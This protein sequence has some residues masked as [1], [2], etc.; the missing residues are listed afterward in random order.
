MPDN[1]THKAKECEFKL[2]E[3]IDL[4]NKRHLGTCICGA[5][6]TV[7][8]DSLKKGTFC[9]N[10]ECKY[11]Q[12]ARRFDLTDMK[13]II[14][15]KKCIYVNHFGSGN[16]KGVEIICECKFEQDLL[17]SHFNTEK[18]CKNFKCKHYRD[19]Q[20][21][22]TEAIKDLIES[23]G[24][25]VPEN[26]EYKTNQQYVLKCPNNHDFK[27]TIDNWKRYPNSRCITCNGNGRSLSLQELREF[28]S[29]YDC[30]IK[31]G[32]TEYKGNVTDYVV[33]YICPNGHY[34]N[35]LTKNNFNG[36]INQNLGPCETCNEEKRKNDRFDEISNQLNTRDCK[37]I[38]L[39]ER[40]V[41][42]ICKCG[43][44]CSSYDNNILKDN[45]IGCA[46][47]GNPF[48][49][50]EIQ[51]QI[52]ETNKVKYGCENVFQS[53]LIKEKIKETNKER[54]GCE[55]VMQNKEIFN[56]NMDSSKKYKNY[57]FPSGRIDEIQ[58]FENITLDY[59]LKTYSENDIFTEKN[60][61]IK[62]KYK[63]PLTNNTSAY[64]PD[65]YVKS[66]NMIVETKSTYTFEKNIEKNEAKFKKVVELGHKM[67]VFI[68]SK[69]KVLYKRI[70][71][72]DG[73]IV[74]EPSNPATLIFED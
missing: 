21:L 39:N 25:K 10:K 37:I 57:R 52:K 29:K 51:E 63:N 59:L 60:I 55:N 71:N 56:R 7:S 9:R 48:N 23:E 70:Y 43:N 73:S 11:Y 8:Y 20:Q 2:Q 40:K 22:S 68:C 61:N 35:N 69:E 45:F 62:I 33:P 74:I 66:E 6:Q 38:S 26:F 72:S 3:P 42:Y 36:R 49:S 31:Y 44:E 13:I 17:W 28:Y 15:E 16:K 34:I 30:E 41:K 50:K 5:K 18:W 14:E 53:E 58:G 32:E 64:Y 46:T 27:T 1:P 65:A 47:C 54:Y 24:Y 12:T 67:I 4:N 19:K